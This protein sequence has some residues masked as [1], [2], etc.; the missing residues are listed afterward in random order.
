LRVFAPSKCVLH[1]KITFMAASARLKTPLRR[2]AGES[3]CLTLLASP[4]MT[5]GWMYLAFIC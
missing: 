1:G 5:V 2:N 3:L 4:R